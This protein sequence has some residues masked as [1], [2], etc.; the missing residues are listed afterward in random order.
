V[1]GFLELIWLGHLPL[2]GH[3]PPNECLAA[4]V[5][6]SAAILSTPPGSTPDHQAV[7]LA[8]L[9]APIVAHSAS[10]IERH[11]RWI[12]GWLVDRAR[13]GIVSGR[14]RPWALNLAGLGLN[15]LFSLL[16]LSLWVPLAIGALLRYRPILPP[17]VLQALY[18]T[19]YLWPLVGVIALM[20]TI[21]ARRPHWL[22]L[23]GF[24]LALVLFG[25]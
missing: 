12:N 25:L 10:H 4:T 13:A 20:G 16:F 1:G 24:G 3:L 15:F 6:A 23:F 5:A 11:V 9:L 8:C 2:G 7:V 19:Y 18:A 22:W 17:F 21:N 14:P